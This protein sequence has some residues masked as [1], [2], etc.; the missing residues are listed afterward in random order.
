MAFT[1]FDDYPA[2]ANGVDT[3][4]GS[5]QPPAVDVIDA[6]VAF[7]VVVCL[8]GI[9]CYRLHAVFPDKNDEVCLGSSGVGSDR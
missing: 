1:L 7:G 9:A 3:P 6:A 5:R 2:P 4:S 8:Y